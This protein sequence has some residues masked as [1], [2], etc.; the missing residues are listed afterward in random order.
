MESEALLQSLT[1]NP[2][3]SSFQMY[4]EEDHAVEFVYKEPKLTSLSEI[5]DRLFAQYKQKFGA[6]VVKLIM[7][8]SP[9]SSGEKQTI[10]VLVFGHPF[11]IASKNFYLSKNMQTF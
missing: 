7:D 10:A 4:F 11:G 9:V 5:S 8:S 1:I 2:H 3:F 6:D